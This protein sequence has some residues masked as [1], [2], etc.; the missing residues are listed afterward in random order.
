MAICLQNVTIRLDFHYSWEGG[1][2]SVTFACI[3][4]YCYCKN[5]EKI[6]RGSGFRNGHLVISII[7][8]KGGGWCHIHMYYFC[9]IVVIPKTLK[10]SFVVRDLDMAICLQNVTIRLD[11]HYS[12]EG[13]GGGGGGVTFT[14]TIYYCY[15]K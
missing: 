8:G 4:Y 9:C 2:D 10:K 12:W 3:T 7:A 15:S 11:F 1:G 6:F 13:G 5:F 14:C